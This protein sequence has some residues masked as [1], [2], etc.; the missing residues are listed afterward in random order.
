MS[1]PGGPASGLSVAAELSV[2]P[3]I[4]TRS[5]SLG[6]H[7]AGR[8]EAVQRVYGIGRGPALRRADFAH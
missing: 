5:P 8:R 3:G 2:R 6:R 7:G 4:G 1:L